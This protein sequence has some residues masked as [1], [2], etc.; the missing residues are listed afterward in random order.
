MTSTGSIVALSGALSNDSPQDNEALGNIAQADLIFYRNVEI[1]AALIQNY[2]NAIL[3]MAVNASH[4]AIK[5]AKAAEKAA[6]SAGGEL[7]AAGG[8]PPIESD[9]ARQNL[10]NVVAATNLLMLNCVTTIQQLDI[11]AQAVLAQSVI[12]VSSSTTE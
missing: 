6:K 9:L 10:A 5:N 1:Q 4:A 8:P 12:L 7:P 2:R 11:M 3:E